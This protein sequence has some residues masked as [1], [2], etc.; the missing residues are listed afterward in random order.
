MI[1]RRF[2]RKKIFMTEGHRTPNRWTHR[3]DSRNSYVD[4]SIE[5][6]FFGPFLFLHTTE[7]GA[8]EDKQFITP[9]WW[10]R[11]KFHLQKVGVTEVF[12][13]VK[14]VSDFDFGHFLEK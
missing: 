1:P 7:E 5:A 11:E 2:K 9:K 14:V 8:V 4:I 13:L 12:L 6:T 3:R 10:D